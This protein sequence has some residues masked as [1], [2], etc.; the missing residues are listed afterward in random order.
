MLPK[1]TS[2]IVAS[3]KKSSYCI[4]D[5]SEAWVQYPKIQWVV[6][7]FSIKMQILGS[8]TPFFHIFSR[9]K[10]SIWDLGP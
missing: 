6:I 2:N 5:L 8:H 9:H 3:K 1:Y 4:F 10:H 7:M